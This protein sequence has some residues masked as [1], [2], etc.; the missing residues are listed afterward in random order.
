VSLAQGEGIVEVGK[1][2]EI[3]YLLR[4]WAASRGDSCLSFQV[5]L[6]SKTAAI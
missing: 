2:E 6:I 4:V 5:S 1:E 3:A